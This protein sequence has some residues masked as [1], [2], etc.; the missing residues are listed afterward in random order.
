QRRRG[1]ARQR[2]EGSPR[3][4]EQQEG[5]SSIEITRRTFASFALLMSVLV[6][7]ARVT[8]AGEWQVVKTYNVRDIVLT[9][10]SP[11]AESQPG[12]NRWVLEFDSAPHKR[13]I[14]AGCPTLTATCRAVSNQP[15]RAAAR[16]SRADVPGRYVGAITL[17]RA[18]EWSIAVGWNGPA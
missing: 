1:E 10:L 17:P 8:D 16:L 14:E 12:E 13:L 4:H 5:G 2:L 15:I 9:F 3:A 6:A 11:V 7:G 18:G